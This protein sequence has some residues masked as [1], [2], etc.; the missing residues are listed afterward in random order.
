MSSENHNHFTREIR[1]P[2]ECY[3]CDRYWAITLTRSN[4]DHRNVIYGTLEIL[5]GHGSHDALM[6]LTQEAS[7][8]KINNYED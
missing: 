8:L 3:S 6:F 4:K 1:K 5:E 2:G 7:R